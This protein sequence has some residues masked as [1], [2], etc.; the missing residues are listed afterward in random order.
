MSR[1]YQICVRCVM[2]TA[3]DP[4]IEFDRNG[5][6]NHCRRYDR[7]VGAC[8][9]P[10]KEGEQRLDAI[11]KEMKRHG[12]NKEYDCVLGVSGGVDSTYTAYVARKLGLRPLAVHLDNGWDSELAVCNIEGALKKLD[13]DLYTHVIDWDEFRDLQ[14]SYLK[15]GLINIEALTDHAIMAVL[16]QAANERDIRYVVTGHNEVTEG[17]LPRSW[18]YTPFDLVCIEDIQSKFGTVELKTFPR[19]GMPRQYYYRYVK[20]IRTVNLLN[21]VSYV[22]KDAKRLLEHEFGWKE[23]S[24]KHGECTFT[25]FYQSYI[26]P[27]RLNIDKRRGHLSCLVCSGEI[28]REEALIELQCPPYSEEGLRREKEYVIKKLGL[29]EEQFENYMNMPVRSHRAFKRD[30]VVTVSWAL[31]GSGPLGR[32]VR[33]ILRCVRR[34]RDTALRVSRLLFGKDRDAHAAESLR[35]RQ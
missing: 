18:G 5:I 15:S 31:T 34:A 4:D 21:F 1:N 9:F 10:G 13:I 24:G 6:C 17:I 22:K 23:Y 7:L 32:T 2:D 29:T 14:L 35:L 12:R 20:G 27:R 3:A 30:I 19:L 33:A 25:Y 16:Y 8:T 11:T 26:L 28:S